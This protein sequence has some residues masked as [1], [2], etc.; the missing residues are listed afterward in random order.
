MPVGH[1]WN[2]SGTEVKVREALYGIIILAFG[3]E[4]NRSG[5]GVKFKES[6]GNLRVHISRNLSE[7]CGTGPEP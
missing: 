6:L 5:T 3:T 2:R 1:L 4:W 7:P